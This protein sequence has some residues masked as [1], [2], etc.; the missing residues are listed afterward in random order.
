MNTAYININKQYKKLSIH[1]YQIIIN[2]L[3]ILV[4]IL[5]HKIHFENV[6]LWVI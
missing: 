5:I 4:S 6:D 1:F 2:I 3:V